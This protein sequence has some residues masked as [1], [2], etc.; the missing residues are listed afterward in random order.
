[1]VVLARL[2]FISCFWIVPKLGRMPF[3]LFV[4]LSD[5]LKGNGLQIDRLE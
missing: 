1:M 3:V 5:R 4:D 2:S